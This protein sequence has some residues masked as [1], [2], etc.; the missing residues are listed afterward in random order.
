MESTR[1]RAPAI[2]VWRTDGDNHELRLDLERA[3]AAGRLVA[4]PTDTVYGVGGRWDRSET[5]G[6][7]RA[8]KGSD[9]ARPFQVLA[10]GPE[11]FPPGL[12]LW[13]ALAVR[14]AGAFWPGPLTIV[15][16]TADGGAIGLRSPAHPVTAAVVAAS[17]GALRAS[18]ANR[19]GEPSART[20]AEVVERLGHGLALVVDGGPAGLGA[21]SSV[22]RVFEEE[23]TLLR[24]EALSREALTQA[25]GRPPLGEKT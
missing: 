18:S 11:S 3:L 7:L 6:L 22:V 12:V 2:R 23:W 14:L 1:N 13:P 9:A 4:F 15:A 5:A 19:A 10:G 21:A 17:G 20:A 25:A 8:L 16:A 24:E